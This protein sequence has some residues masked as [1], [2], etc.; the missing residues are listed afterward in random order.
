MAAL[1]LWLNCI[2]DS[3]RK[4]HVIARALTVWIHS[5]VCFCCVKYDVDF[6][7]M[8]LRTIEAI[9]PMA[10]ALLWLSSWLLLAW[11]IASGSA[12]QFVTHEMITLISIATNLCPCSWRYLPAFIHVVYSCYSPSLFELSPVFYCLLYSEMD[13][14]PGAPVFHF[15]CCFLKIII[16]MRICGLVILVFF[17]RNSIFKW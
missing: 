4:T 6:Y 2:N 1:C 7:L 9:L 16:S 10:F 17:E 5:L 3:S 11:I 15:T 14:E 12:R 8:S 13:G